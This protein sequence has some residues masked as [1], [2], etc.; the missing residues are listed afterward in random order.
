MEQLKGILIGDFM[1]TGPI[2]VHVAATL[3]EAYQ[4][5]RDHGVR[6]LPVVDDSGKLIGI[7]S[8]RDLNHAYPPRETES[9]WYYDKLELDL[10]NVRHFM[11]QDPMTLRPE[12]T[13]HDAVQIFMNSKIGCL[14]I[15]NSD[16]KLV[17]I[18]SYIDAL[19]KIA[20]LA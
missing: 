10:L 4:D 5:M 15:V 14:P 8:D 1:V 19:K 16:K 13:L 18:I 9:G 3:A 12:N 20:S 17:G 7:F 2:V 11:K 6:H